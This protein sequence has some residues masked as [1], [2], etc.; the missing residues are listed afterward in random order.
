MVLLLA[1]RELYI[2]KP[3]LPGYFVLTD[4][5]PSHV[6]PSVPLLRPAWRITFCLTNN[7]K[8]Q[9]NLLKRSL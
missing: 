5:Q 6:L 7:G 9:Y 4:W 8:C 3:D 2:I 1:L